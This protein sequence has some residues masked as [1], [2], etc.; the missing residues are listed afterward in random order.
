VF[1][2][3]FAGALASRWAALPSFASPLHATNKHTSMIASIGL[4]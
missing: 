4:T 1:P 2:D 3:S